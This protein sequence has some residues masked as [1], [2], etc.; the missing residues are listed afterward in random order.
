M[1]WQASGVRQIPNS[2][3]RKKKMLTFAAY[4]SM[5]AGTIVYVKYT[6]IEVG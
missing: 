4:D 3:F 2:M 1:T 5:R 6:A